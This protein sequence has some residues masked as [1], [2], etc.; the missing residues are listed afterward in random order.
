MKS[1]RTILFCI[2]CCNY[3]LQ[4]QPAGIRIEGTNI[5]LTLNQELPRDIQL[6]ILSQF[7]M[8]KLSLDS[9]WQFGAIGKWGSEG[10]KVQKSN[11]GNISIYKP[12][13]ALSGKMIKGAGSYLP[14]EMRN[15]L[16]QQTQTTFGVNNFR[17]QN[18]SSLPNGKTR[19]FFEGM[20]E[21]GNVHLSGTFNAWST[22]ATP[23]VRV[24]SG[25]IAD[26]RLKAGKHCYKYI[27]DGHWVHDLNNK[28]REDDGH[29][30]SNSIYF[31]YNHVFTL[32][33]HEQARNVILSG[34]FVNWDE[35]T[36]RMNKVKDGWALPVYLKEGT[37]AY[38]FIVDGNWINDPAN[39]FKVN[40]GKGNVN[41]LLNLG[42]TLTFSLKGFTNSKQV[43]LAG[44]FNNWDG[45][46]L[47]MQK[48]ASGWSL[49]ITLAPGNYQ[50]KFVVDGRWMRDPAN[51]HTA[52]SD[53][54]TNSLLAYMPTHTFV[55]KDP[56]K[57]YK[58]VKVT[59]NFNGWTGYS[60]KETSTGWSIDVYLP[61]GKCLYKF[62]VN[63]D[64]IVDPQNPQWEENEFNNGN[65]VVWIG[66]HQ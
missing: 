30:G 2:I 35:K 42:D 27:I 25:W 34:S 39:Q 55:L 62:I 66:Q 8:Q 1:L 22:L 16:D 38:K 13:N 41:S 3:S 45:N 65:S 49:P 7:G 51:P 54:V 40:D 50:Y 21:A 44:T 17:K 59:G 53:G 9:L 47:A 56:Q 19:F 11:K 26:V 43:F 24:D 33:G 52:D 60:M 63:G 4:A 15:L 61:T 36:L 5:V 14:N 29:H 6:E 32:K 18:I 10:W 37:H 48:N 12:V 57:K 64:W 31:V 58:E 46:S 20:Q 23:M 28:V